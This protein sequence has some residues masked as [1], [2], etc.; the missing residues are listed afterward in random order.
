M[1]LKPLLRKIYEADEKKLENRLKDK[2]TTLGF[3]GSAL[4][5]MGLFALNLITTILVFLASN[6][7]AASSVNWMGKTITLILL[8][9]ITLLLVEIPLM[10]YFLVP[11][12]ADNILSNLNTWIQKR[13]H[14]LT[15]GLVI[16][17]GI[18]ILFEGLN[19]LNLI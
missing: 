6:Q 15:A 5:A 10:I 1:A 8:V 17:I 3:F 12:K 7:I 16:I 9:T 11:Q 4:L 2:Y 18:Y 13:G 14:Y 19:E